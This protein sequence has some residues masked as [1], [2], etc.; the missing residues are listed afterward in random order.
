M[1]LRARGPRDP[2]TGWER[3]AFTRGSEVLSA[4][5]LARSWFPSIL[6]K[7]FSRKLQGLQLAN[8]FLSRKT[9]LKDRSLT[10][11]AGVRKRRPNKI[12]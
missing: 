10:S 4:M 6:T 2:C 3:W 8:A 11:P 12:E 9:L 7:S 5:C 1:F